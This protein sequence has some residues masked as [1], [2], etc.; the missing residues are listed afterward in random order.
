[1]KKN[2]GEVASNRFVERRVAGRRNTKS[3][4]I[5]VGVKGFGTRTGLPDRRVRIT[6]QE[7]QQ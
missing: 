4:G 3:V 7:L 5:S 2:I 6:K 1:M